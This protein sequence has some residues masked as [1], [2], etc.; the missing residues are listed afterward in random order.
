M[1]PVSAD[2]KAYT[3]FIRV[4]DKSRFAVNQYPDFLAAIIP[5][6]ILA[7]INYTIILFM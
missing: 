1:I 5:A 3:L 4:I 7:I 6:A 2:S